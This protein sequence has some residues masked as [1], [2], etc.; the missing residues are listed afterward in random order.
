MAQLKD[1]I[2][3]GDSRFVGN[4]YNNSAMVAYGTCTTAAATAAKEIVISD[5]SWTLKVGN[6]IAVKFTYSNSA[7]NTTL[8]VNGSGAK[9]IW[10][11]NAVYTSNSS[12]VSGYANRYTYYMYD[13]TY[14]VW[15]SWSLDAEDNIY[16]RTFLN[17]ERRYAGT[18]I[19]PYHLA[20]I[21]VD[22]R[23]QP[24]TPTA[25]TGTDHVA[26]TVAVR[27]DKIYYVNASGTY[28]A[29]AVVGDN[30]LYEII[31]VSS[32]YNFNASIPAYRACYLKGKY[33]ST[34]GLF[35]LDNTNTTSYYVY[36]PTNT[37]SIKLTDYFVN[38]YN[39]IYV[40]ASDETANHLQLTTEHTMYYFDGTNLVP[41]IGKTIWN[42][43]S[44]PTATIG[45]D[46]DIYVQY[47]A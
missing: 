5:P 10:W 43:T 20:M 13:G 3:T 23:L 38:G 16:D 31:P 2:V 44:A 9:Q 26:N 14:W 46:G 37:A 7:S 4:V 19:P 45:A 12:T 40:G 21:D 35:T 34:T 1:L 41:T 36:T 32:N 18:A 30:T 8:N 42:G 24:I 11:N 27:P 25:G 22:G 47:T 39:Y 15:M 6:I 28:A 17:Y 33:N 29:G